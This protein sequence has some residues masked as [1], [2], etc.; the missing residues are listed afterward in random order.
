MWLL[1]TSTFSLEFVLEPR[2]YAILSHTWEKEEGTF[3]GIKDLDAVK[4]KTGW[5]KIEQTC[6][7]ARE[8]W[9]LEHA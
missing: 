9:N 3:S 1:N 6:R 7:L 4:K 5:G 2:Y 8:L